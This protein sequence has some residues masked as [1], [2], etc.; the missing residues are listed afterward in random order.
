MDPMKTKLLVLLLVFSAMSLQSQ[1]LESLKPEALKFYEG[2]YYMDFK[3]VADLTHPKVIENS[4][5]D[6]FIQKLD[7]EYQNAEFRKRLQL[8]QPVFSYAAIK[9][10]E[11]QAFC[12][13]T[14]KNPTRY[15]FE[16]KLD[17]AT[18]SQKVNELKQTTKATEV[19]YE[20]VRNSI[21][22]KRSSK[23]VAVF[24]ESTQNQ[25]K[26][27]NFDDPMQQEMFQ[28]LYSEHIKKQLGL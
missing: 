16:Q 5:I 11:G 24:D 28:K 7:T 15:F 3:S 18:A 26:F 23:L 25:W 8:A 1:T 4:D 14:Y 17:A 2:H 6:A 10:I 22:V 27:F 21:N 9:T 12:V 13:I 20:P 19:I